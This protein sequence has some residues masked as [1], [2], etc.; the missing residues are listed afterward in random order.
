MGNVRLTAIA[1]DSLAVDNSFTVL[2]TNHVGQDV[3]GV[4]RLNGVQDFGLLVAN[5]VR[6]EGDG[7]LHG[8]HGEEL[9]EVIGNHVAERAGG[10]VETTAVFDADGFRGGDLN[11]I[12]VIAIPERL[13]DVVGK[14]ED[15]HV[16]H[17]LFAEI[18]VDAVDLFLV[19]ASSSDRH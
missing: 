17:G 3:F 1:G 4:D 19:Q 14:A 6:I 16:L 11:V 8:R 2:A 15:H 12:D 13:D 18:V 7:R 10:F 9:K 5:F